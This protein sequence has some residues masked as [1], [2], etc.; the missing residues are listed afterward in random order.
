MTRAPHD[1]VASSELAFLE[2]LREHFAEALE[3]A[4]RRLT[5]APPC[6]AERLYERVLRYRR[7]KGR[8][9]NRLRVAALVEAA[10]G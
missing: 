4:Q 10:E 9:E 8:V 5:E 7:V 1:P 6:D 3:E 2:P